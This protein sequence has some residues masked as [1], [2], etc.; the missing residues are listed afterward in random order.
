MRVKL[1]FALLLLCSITARSATIE[2]QVAG[3]TPSAEMT[4][5]GRWAWLAGGCSV[6]FQPHV[7]Q[8]K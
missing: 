2:G 1:G 7:S 8:A 6:G 5:D 4:L 3:E